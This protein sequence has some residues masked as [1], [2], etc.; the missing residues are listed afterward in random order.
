MKTISSKVAPAGHDILDA[1]EG[2]T[3]WRW[4]RPWFRHDSVR[5]E[6]EARRTTTPYGGLALFHS[7]AGKL[8]LAEAI[9]R[10]L[11]IFKFHLPYTEADHILTQ[12]YNLLC[13]G[14]CL[15]DI[16]NLQNSEAIRRM[17][18]AKT[19]PDP[20]TAGDFLRRFSEGHIRDLQRAIDQVRV[21][22]WRKLP[23]PKRA[24][25]TIDLDSHIREVY[26]DCKQGADFSYTGQW[27]YHPLLATLA[28]TGE[29]LRV[30]N[31]PGNATS[32][33]GAAEVLAECLRLTT[34]HF[35]EV[36]WRGDSAFYVAE[37]LNLSRRHGAHFVV[38]VGAMAN[39][40][41]EAEKLPERAWKPMKWRPDETPVAPEEQRA[42]RVDYRR[43]KV[44]ERGYRNLEPDRQEV[45]E[46]DYR[47]SGCDATYRMVVRRVKIRE[48]Q[49]QKV[50]WEGYRYHFMITDERRWS[51]EEVVRFGYGRCDIENDI[52]QLENGLPAMRMPTGELRANWAFLM[53]GQ[54]AW[55]L[56]AW[57]AALVLPE[58]TGRWEWKR[59]RQ[60]FIYIG[61]KVIH[62]A[63]RV[64]AK[65]SG[66]HR[67]AAEVLRA[68]NRVAALNLSG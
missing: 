26:G 5:V 21:K 55:N 2:R 11:R 56:K 16:A 10:E 25:A 58:E 65:I 67:Y 12:T 63:R 35:D 48:A 44:Q 18:G 30:V 27:S 43:R 45:A 19:I 49:G 53:M 1:M 68:L 39:L 51:A 41:R 15:E 28:E 42:K 6:V 64:V 34:P 36:Y 32:P 22:V 24:R 52:E 13:G 66:A 4:P 59:F 38:V 20:T 62:Q 3:G 60:A 17:L 14:T 54:I 9:N 61:A 33:Q 23:R 40:V 50:I 57:A 31:R 7:L 46:F 47:P 29:W 8:G 37:L